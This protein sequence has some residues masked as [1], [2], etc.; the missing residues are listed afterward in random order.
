MP[1]TQEMNRRH[2]IQSTA[3]A[4]VATSIAPVL[5]SMA[6]EEPSQGVHWP[7]GCFNRPWSGEKHNWGMD[8]ALDGMKAAGYKLTGLLSGNAK[9]PLL[10]SNATPEY[11]AGLKKRIAERGL[12]VNMGALRTKN[13]LPLDAQIKDM[14]KQ[15]DN[16]KEV[17]VQF[18]LTFGVDKPEYFENYYKLMQD[19]AA[20]SQEHGLK[21]VL[22]P[23]GGASGAS[24]EIIRCLDK[25]GHPNF[26]IWFDAGNIIYYTGK[27][28]VEQLKPIVEHVTG[29]CAKD[30]DKQGGTVWLEFGTGKVDFHAVFGEMKKG[31]FNG[32]IMVECCA[33]GETPEAVTAN[34]R[35]NREY[36]EKVFASL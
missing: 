35:K 22:K 14:R 7:I 17:G 24:E 16:G 32:P 27:D 9:E 10:G 12:G 36:L 21:L 6:A 19:A 11:I 26:K 15:I 30:C 31:G 18:L 3:F 4:A 33:L 25:V 5:N 29:F 23:H 2:F 34:A 28:P 8:V 20:Y 1:I 13:D